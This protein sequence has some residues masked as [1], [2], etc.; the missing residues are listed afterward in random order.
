MNIQKTSDEGK[1]FKKLSFGFFAPL[2][3]NK[4]NHTWEW[5]AV[6]KIPLGKK[7]RK[8]SEGHTLLLVLSGAGRM[9]GGAKA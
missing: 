9:R 4:V 5:K 1:P 3:R 6:E 7:E 8:R 2:Q